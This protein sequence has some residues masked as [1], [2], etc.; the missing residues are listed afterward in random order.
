MCTFDGRLVLQKTIYLL[1]AFGIY[2]GYNFSWYLHGPYSTTLTRNGFALQEIYKN[3][4]KGTFENQKTQRKFDKFIQFMDDKK[5]DS[6]KI[7]ILASIHFLKNI[8]PNMPKY[9]IL[10]IVKKKQSY[11]T[12]KQCN[13]G[14]NELKKVNLI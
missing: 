5:N 4:E 12:E 1:Q 10:D 7:E 6:D 14:W 11:F 9:K 2:L 3:I 8:Y 13:D